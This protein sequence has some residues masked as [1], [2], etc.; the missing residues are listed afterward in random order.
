MNTDRIFYSRPQTR[1]GERALGQ[2]HY[3]YGFAARY[4]LDLLSSRGLELLEV[5]APEQF[6]SRTFARTL[7][8]GID[9]AAHPHLIFRSTEDIRP[10]PGAYNIACFAWEFEV[11]SGP[12]SGQEAVLESQTSMLSTCQEIWTPSR[13]AQRVLLAHGLANVHVI[14]APMPIPARADAAVE[15]RPKAKRAAWAKLANV[16]SIPLVS[17]SSNFV[18]HY[19]ADLEQDYERLARDKTSPLGEQPALNWVLEGGGTVIVTVCNPYDRRK[20]LANLIEGFL[21]AAVDRDDVVLVVKLATSGVVETPAGYLYHQ[22]RLLFGRPHC[23]FEEKVV[24]VGGYLE[25]EQME[26]LYAGADFYLCTSVAEGQNLPLLEAMAMA[27]APITVANTAMSDYIDDEVAVVVPER[28]F[29]GLL[30]QMAADGA[31]RRYGS[32]L[33][34]RFQIGHAIRR[35]LAMPQAAREAMGAA[36]KARITLLFSPD[37]VFTRIR[38]RLDAIGRGAGPDR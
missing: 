12:A 3:S 32:S 6:K 28:R 23:L 18:T 37:E 30:T 8:Q 38:A 26:A 15:G 7:G 4:F 5:S 27:V 2:T 11:L 14:P 36:A 9:D 1:G 33:S 29:E 16:P 17:F 19:E 10:I 25:T 24:L 20:N 22:L 21:L 13:Y 31:R 34:D 35:A